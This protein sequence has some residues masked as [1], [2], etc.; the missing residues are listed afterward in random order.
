MPLEPL[1]PAPSCLPPPPAPCLESCQAPGLWGA[2]RASDSGAIG[3]LPIPIPIPA[4]PGTGIGAGALLG[5]GLGTS[6]VC[7]D[8]V[9]GALHASLAGREAGTRQTIAS[10]WLPGS[11]RLVTS[12]LKP[13]GAGEGP[14]VGLAPVKTMC[15]PVVLPPVVPAPEA[16]EGVVGRA[17]EPREHRV[18]PSSASETGSHHYKA[19]VAAPS[20]LEVALDLETLSLGGAQGGG[21]GK[22]ALRRGRGLEG[23]ASDPASPDS[24]LSATFSLATIPHDSDAQ[25][26]ISVSPTDPTT[27]PTS[28]GLGGGQPTPTPDAASPHPALEPASSPGAPATSAH[29]LPPASWEGDARRPPCGPSVH[30][31]TASREGPSPVRQAGLGQPCHQGRGT[32][33]E[34]SEGES[35]RKAPSISL[36]PGTLDVPCGQAASSDGAHAPGLQTHERCA[37]GQPTAPPIS[38][39]AS[40]S[41][42][43]AGA[44]PSRHSGATAAAQRPLPAAPACALQPRPRGTPRVRLSL[45]H[46]ASADTVVSYVLALGRALKEGR[47]GPLQGGA[48]V[49][50]GSCCGNQEVVMPGPGP[51][52]ETQGLGGLAPAPVASWVPAT[53]GLDEAFQRERD[54][55]KGHFGA[56]SLCRERASSKL[57]ACKTILKSSLKVRNGRIRLSFT[58]TSA[59]SGW[60]SLDPL[61]LQ[62]LHELH[63]SLARPLPPCGGLYKMCLCVWGAVRLLSLSAVLCCAVLVCL[64]CAC[65]EEGGCGRAMCRG[66]FDAHNPA[67]GFGLQPPGTPVRGGRGR[68]CGAPDSGL[69]QWGGPV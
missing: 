51:S 55:G 1:P 11:H 10:A 54:L 46:G 38:A 14:Q 31:G 65:A 7:Q 66:G 56:V 8:A 42:G 28:E 49:K 3:A 34:H 37:T 60:S 2:S 21:R 22:E 52:G 16:G 5:L 4:S 44:T 67:H 18:F 12:D 25:C 59:P 61:L 41:G 47:A 29:T 58:Q 57:F 24:T 63:H 20:A 6:L 69:L 19:P 36:C 64:R 30:S 53:V 39:T 68:V 9:Q 40:L 62:L 17:G 13:G 33:T 26:S 35:E 43:G 45:R 32:S 27:P 23:D 15:G 48:A 50:E